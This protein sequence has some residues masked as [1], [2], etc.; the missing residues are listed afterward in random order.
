FN[1][2]YSTTSSKLHKYRKRRRYKSSDSEDEPRRQC[3]PTSILTWKILNVVYEN[4][5]RLLVAIATIGRE[6]Y[7]TMFPTTALDRMK[8]CSYECENGDSRKRYLSSIIGVLHYTKSLFE[9]INT[10]TLIS[11]YSNGAIRTNKN[12]VLVFQNIEALEAN[13]LI[14]LESDSEDGITTRLPKGD[15]LFKLDVDLCFS[16]ELLAMPL[17]NNNVSSYIMAKL[18]H[19]LSFGLMLNFDSTTY[20]SL[21][22][23]SNPL[24]STPSTKIQLQRTDFIIVDKY[25]VVT[26]EDD[27]TAIK[28]EKA[29]NSD[30]FINCKQMYR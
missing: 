3:T 24:I 13:S 17:L 4:T 28:E 15:S 22:L 10:F 6:G 18:C 16:H 19:D 27:E 29:F 23:L 30:T 11:I 12:S 20:P 21:T 1:N 5:R 26:K 7:N 8:N 9:E 25:K 2:E 14:G